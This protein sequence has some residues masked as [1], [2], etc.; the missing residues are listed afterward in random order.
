MFFGW[1]PFQIVHLKEAATYLN[2]LNGRKNGKDGHLDGHLDGHFERW[3]NETFRLDGHLD[4]HFFL[5][6]EAF[7]YEYSFFVPCFLSF[8]N[9]CRG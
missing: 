4:G 5:F 7:L 3:K 1:Y 8:I 2:G 6:L 9:Y